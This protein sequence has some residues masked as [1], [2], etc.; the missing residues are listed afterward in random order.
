MV[1]C[2]CAVTDFWFLHY[3]IVVNLKTDFDVQ[4]DREFFSAK[5]EKQGVSN[6][7]VFLAAV[8]LLQ[9]CSSSSAVIS[10]VTNGLNAK[11]RFHGSV[12]GL[13]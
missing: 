5:I 10:T 3:R 2:A 1:T 13:R 6:M 8:S 4:V 9:M 7:N 11:R 12:R